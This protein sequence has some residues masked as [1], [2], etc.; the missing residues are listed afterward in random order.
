[1]CVCMYNVL[2]SEGETGFLGLR[3]G[4]K[5]LLEIWVCNITNLLGTNGD[6]GL[7][8]SIIYLGQKGILKFKNK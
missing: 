1:M 5:V 4:P 3:G 7:V 8:K 2:C 6:F